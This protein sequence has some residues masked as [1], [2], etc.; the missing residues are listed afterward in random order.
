M[1]EIKFRAWDKVCKEYLPNIQNHIGPVETAFG[2]MIKN[3]RYVIEQSKG[4]KDI[5]G[6]EIHH[7]DLINVFFTSGDGEH[8]HDCVYRVIDGDLGGIELRF[9]KLMWESYGYNQNTLYTVLTPKY[10]CLGTDYVNRNYDKLAVLETWGKNHI[11][12]GSWKEL[13]YSNYFKIIGTVNQN[14]ELLTNQ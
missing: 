12:G 5:S 3:D 6:V 14:P 7:G 10:S 8:I 13:D 2:G 9:A 4:L 11:Q 1:R